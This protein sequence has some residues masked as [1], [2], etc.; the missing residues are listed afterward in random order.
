MNAKT[1]AATALGVAASLAALSNSGCG[2]PQSPLDSLL[3]PVQPGLSKVEEGWIPVLQDPL[4]PAI[5][6]TG[7]SPISS[8]YASD[9]PWAIYAPGFL[10]DSSQAVTVLSGTDL[11]VLSF[12][13]LGTGQSDV[14]TDGINTLQTNS[15]AIEYLTGLAQ[16]HGA[17]TIVYVGYS[18]GARLIATA[19]TAANA[20]GK[21]NPAFNGAKCVFI[22]SDLHQP[23]VPLETLRSQLVDDNSDLDDRRK[24]SLG[25]LLSSI[26][27]AIDPTH[28]R[29][30]HAEVY[31]VSSISD[32]LFRPE[33][34]IHTLESLRE[35]LA[36][37]DIVEGTHEMGAQAVAA[38]QEFVR[39]LVKK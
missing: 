15:P 22:N 1:I 12:D 24:Q 9:V 30:L 31:M 26:Y 28:L 7:F 34:A 6:Y 2:L 36:N 37:L 3:P 5:H 19:M 33:L 32:P 25:D 39:R 27:V 18:A 4:G 23:A 21:L 14:P 16:S 17:T 29:D 35:S 20:E 8:G 10:C 13:P 38:A 11:N